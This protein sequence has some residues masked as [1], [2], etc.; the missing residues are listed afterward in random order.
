MT[1]IMWYLQYFPF[2]LVLANSTL[3]PLDLEISLWFLFDTQLLSTSLPSIVLPLA[4]LLDLW[5]FGS[6]PSCFYKFLIQHLFQ[7]H[8]AICFLVASDNILAGFLANFGAKLFGFNP[9]CKAKIATLSDGLSTTC[10]A[11]ENLLINS[12]SIS[13]IPSK[14][15]N[16]VISLIFNDHRLA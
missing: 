5:K 10:N 6:F 13:L 7:F 15:L 11:I 16:Y 4:S 14:V 9:N 1:I 2:C 3:N 8:F 12:L